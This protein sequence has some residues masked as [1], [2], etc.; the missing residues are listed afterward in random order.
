MAEIKRLKL[1][2]FTGFVDQWLQ[3]DLSRNRKQRHTAKGIFERMRDEHGYK[4][5]YDHWRVGPDEGRSV[6]V[7]AG[8]GEAGKADAIAEP[9]AKPRAGDLAALGEFQAHARLAH[10]RGD[11]PFPGGD[12]GLHKGSEVMADFQLQSHLISL[13]CVTTRMVACQY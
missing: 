7:V 5:G 4:G 6:Q 12:F 2:G 10:G 8:N 9:G 3:E 1:D 11:S 13:F